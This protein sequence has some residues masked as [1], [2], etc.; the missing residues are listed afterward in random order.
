MT[1]WWTAETYGL[2][3]EVELDLSKRM[4]IILLVF[5]LT[6]TKLFSHRIQEVSVV[7]QKGVTSSKRGMELLISM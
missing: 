6:G 2:Q 1:C 7:I 4:T 5:C 3:T